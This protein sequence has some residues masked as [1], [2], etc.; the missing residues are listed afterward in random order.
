MKTEYKS[1]KVTGWGVDWRK[2][3]FIFTLQ[4]LYPKAPHI[5]PNFE[6]REKTKSSALKSL[7]SCHFEKDNNQDSHKTNK[8]IK[9]N[10]ET[11]KMM[12]LSSRHS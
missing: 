12:E 4:P 6:L 3:L 10:M 7:P 9:T 2:G 5:E 11:R 1:E 8:V